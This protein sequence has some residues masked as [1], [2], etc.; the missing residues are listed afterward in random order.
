MTAIY[1]HSAPCPN[2]KVLND[3]LTASA[4]TNKPSLELASNLEKFGSE[5]SGWECLH[6]FDSPLP[7]LNNPIARFF[8]PNLILRILWHSFIENHTVRR[9]MDVVNIDAVDSPEHYYQ[10]RAN[11]YTQSNVTIRLHLPVCFK[12]NDAKIKDQLKG[13]VKFRIIEN[14]G[15]KEPK[16]TMD[17][18]NTHVVYEHR[19]RLLK[20]ST[21]GV[22][23]KL[24][25]IGNE[26][27]SQPAQTVTA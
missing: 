17:L 22:F 20:N 9:E 6:I 25:D 1:T 13:C 23:W 15:V 4:Y 16:S 10:L 18:S 3:G 5:K 12:S 7:Y 14:A 8:L 11:R 26:A 2:G 27:V 21:F 19:E 24:P